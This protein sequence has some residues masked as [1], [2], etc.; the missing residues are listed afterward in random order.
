MLSEGES[1]DSEAVRKTLYYSDPQTPTPSDPRTLNTLPPAEILPNVSINAS[2]YDIDSPMHSPSHVE[3]PP[4][5][6]SVASEPDTAS[7]PVSAALQRLHNYIDSQLINLVGAA[8][9]QAVGASYNQLADTINEE[10]LS[11]KNQVLQPTRDEDDPMQHDP[12]N[13]NSADVEDNENHQCDRQN[14][15][16][17]AGTTQDDDDSMQHD[18]SND[19]SADGDVEDNRDHQCDRQNRHKVAGTKGKND[20]HKRQQTAGNDNDEEDEDDDGAN[21]VRRRKAPTVLAVR[22]YPFRSHMNLLTQT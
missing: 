13:D 3:V 10:I 7:Q 22:S 18:P 16:K 15:H 11:I 21:H 17:V 9:E 4:P 20:L 6:T 2:A 8:V 5:T 14:R 12:P 1:S 19:N